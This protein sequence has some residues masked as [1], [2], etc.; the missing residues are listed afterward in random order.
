M[1]TTDSAAFPVDLE[2][3]LQPIS[4]REPA[5]EWLRYE[6]T[7]DAVQEARRAE[8]ETLPKGIWQSKV[9]RADFIKVDNL[10]QQAL[11]ERTKDLQIAVW[12]A[13][14]WLV[15]YG[16]A[17]FA[18]G[19]RLCRELLSRFWDTA[20]PVLDDGD[21]AYRLAPLEFLDRK[22]APRLKQIPLTAPIE[23]GEQR[24]ALSFVDWERA[25]HNEKTGQA[26]GSGEVRPSQFLA[27]AAVTPPTLYIALHKDLSALD[28]EAAA[29]EDTVGER[30]GEHTRTLR[31][32]RSLIADILVLIGQYTPASALAEAAPESGAGESG[33][34]DAASDGAADS[35][36]GAGSQGDKGAAAMDRARAGNEGGGGPI[37]SRSEAY[38]RLNEAADYLLRTEP[39]SPVPY[40]VKRAVSWGHMNLLQLMTELVSTEA[41]RYAIF[42]LLGI[43][44]PQ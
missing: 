26:A 32:L 38:E 3:L 20:Y 22:V 27:A 25:L 7:Y 14:A 39:H 9:K 41:D 5:G 36:A 34:T 42:T 10:C 28:R 17:G 44:P 8:D 12:L 37:R 29:L 30:T 15:R 1:T 19:L 43:K 35:G 2:T 23:I 4:S 13:E 16:P 21:A 33:D 11:R 18:A 40:L 24:P 6:G 31:G